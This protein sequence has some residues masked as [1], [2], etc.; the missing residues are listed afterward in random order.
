MLPIDRRV[1]LSAL[2]LGK[3]PLWETL[4][5]VRG[6]GFRAFEFVPHLYGGPAALT[7]E[8]RLRLADEL[9]GFDIVTVH[10]STIRLSTG[11]RADVASEDASLRARSVAQ[12]RDLV[13]L[14][15]DIGAQLVTFHAGY[16]TRDEAS[17]AEREAHRTC[18]QELCAMS[19]GSGLLMGYEYFDHALAGALDLAHSGF[20]VLFDI[21]HAAMR[22]SGDLTEGVLALQ[23]GLRP[24]IVQYH[25]HG[26][27]VAD[28]GSKEDHHPL[29]SDN[30][31][32]YQR[33]VRAIK[34]DDF[35]GPLILETEVWSN[36]DV[37]RILGRSIRARDALVSM[38][39]NG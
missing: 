19:Q 32:D 18:A 27:H 34:D 2:C 14:A 8:R 5:L 39:E 3:T 23:H 1:G 16:G 20:G 35:R 4:R 17:L 13:A 9:A 25:A 21:G 24:Y 12:Y 10:S 11:E 26:V 22:S 29:D 6:A 7:G 30:G 36:R 15:L 28:D 33:V 31:I 38:W 37:G